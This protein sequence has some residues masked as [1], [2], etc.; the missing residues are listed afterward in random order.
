MT[1]NEIETRH[2]AETLERYPWLSTY[3]PDDYPFNNFD[4][5]ACPDCGNEKVE[6]I[7]PYGW[8]YTCTEC[9]EEQE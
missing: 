6:H 3:N 8:K 2:S 4:G 1:W 7:G 5:P 9:D